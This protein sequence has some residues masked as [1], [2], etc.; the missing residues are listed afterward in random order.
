MSDSG[1]LHQAKDVWDKLRALGPF[2]AGVGVPV[3]IAWIGNSYS[4]SIKDAENRVRYVE[5][6]IS[7]L[8][9]T[10]KPE[11]AALRAWAVDLL[12]SQSPVKLS[13][14]AR[15]QLKRNQ[16]AFDFL[17]GSPAQISALRDGQGSKFS[18]A[19]VA[20]APGSR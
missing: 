1:S 18:P 10:P 3:A 17:K 20:S 7:E 9:S 13:P 4:A 16:V 15:E 8:R 11:T 12:D 6:A 2:L 19:S 5:I 14:E